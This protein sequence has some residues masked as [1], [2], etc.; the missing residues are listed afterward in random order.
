MAYNTYKDV[1][2][3]EGKQRDTFEMIKRGDADVILYGGARGSGKKLP[4][5]VQVLTENGF[6]RNGDLT[7]EDKVI[8]PIT[9]KPINILQ[10]HETT[11]EPEYKLHFENGDTIGACK[12][13]LWKAWKAN[14]RVRVKGATR[15]TYQSGKSSNRIYNTETLKKW[16]DIANSGST[17]TKKYPLIPLTEE[18]HYSNGYQPI[19]APYLLGLLLGDGTIVTREHLSVESMDQSII[20][21]CTKLDASISQD[22]KSK[23][24]GLNFKGNFRLELAKHLEE[25]KLLGTRSHNKFIPEQYLHSDIETR[26]ELLR[27]LLDTDGTVADNGKMYYYSTSKDLAEG[28]KSLV[29]SLGGTCSMWSKVGKYKDIKGNVVEC[30]DCWNVYIKHP[31]GADLFNLQRKKDLVKKQQGYYR[32]VIDITIEDPVP[33]RCI[34]VDSEEGLY[35]VG[36][37]YLVTHN[38]ELLTMVPLLFNHDKYYRGIFFRR[39]YS[40]IMGA[41]S[42]W[43]KAGNMYPLFNAKANKSDKTY[44]FPSE[45]IQEFSHMAT[46]ADAETHRG[47]GYSFV[48]FDEVDKFSKD[49]VT[50]LMTCLRSESDSSSFMLG[51]LNPNPDSWC[52]P[53]VDWYLNSDGDPIEERSGV[54]RYFVVD[55][56]DFVFGDTEEWFQ[57]NKPECLYVIN[58]KTGEKIYVPPKRFTFVSATI[59]DNPALIKANPR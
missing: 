8:N 38:S 52:L 37:N 23:S 18:C 22:K 17:V 50:F 32:K 53:L 24:V 56:G 30:K 3:Q 41:N 26:K 7:L 21:Y 40:E 42:L 46:E 25:L 34:T 31:N 14:Q 48:G 6:K 9:G 43:Q 2:P 12:D 58:D 11:T 59:I 28:V 54:I 4:L 16:C 45:A 49:Q 20:D 15:G 29:E 47:L 36:K 35:I 33:M 44:T 5:N 1:K 10:I 55:D 13:H 57:E 19:I 27:G 51:T 39:H